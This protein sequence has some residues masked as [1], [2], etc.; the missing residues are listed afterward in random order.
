MCVFFQAEDGIRYLT[1]TGVQTCALPI[2]IVPLHQD[3]AAV[4]LGDRVQVPAELVG[5]PLAVQVENLVPGIAVHQAGG[6]EVAQLQDRKSTRLNSSH[7]QISYAVFCL[8]KKTKTPCPPSGPIPP[9]PPRRHWRARCSSHTYSPVSKN[10]Y[11]S[12]C[13]AQAWTYTR[14]HPLPRTCS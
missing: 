12:V 11:Q 5:L 7:S 2:L 10:T 3:L 14:T 4:R 6:R 9:S 13:S 1:V 8:K